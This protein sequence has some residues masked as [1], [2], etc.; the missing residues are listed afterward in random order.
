MDN[1]QQ[2]VAFW[3]NNY[4]HKKENYS[5]ACH[6]AAVKYGTDN[7]ALEQLIGLLLD[8]PKET[9]ES[10][11]QIGIRGL[12]HASDKELL[13]YK[14]VGPKG[15]LKIRGVFSFYKKLVKEAQSEQPVIKSPKDVVNLLLPEMKYL[16]REHLKAILLNT[17]NHVIKIITV[18]I[19]GVDS[20][21]GHA[22]EIFKDA[23]K[24]SAFSIILVHNHP[25]GDVT[26]SKKDQD[27]TKRMSEAGDIIGI[28]V[29]DHIILGSK[30]DKYSSLSELGLL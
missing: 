28:K 4:L 30:N 18:S 3:G 17:K 24:E 26:P 23:I 27:F 15:L 14:G 12:I 29:L 11:A 2:Q 8:C 25:S 13:A 10:L 21:P 22:R 19:G 9:A 16:D 5:S 6:D 20:A 1:V 7:L